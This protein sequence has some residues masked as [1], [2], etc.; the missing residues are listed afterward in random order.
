MEKVD[1]HSE[2]IKVCST[3]S[4]DVKNGGAAAEPAELQLQALVYSA[5]RD[6]AAFDAM[7]PKQLRPVLSALVN[8]RDSLLGVMNQ[9]R[10]KE[11]GNVHNYL[12]DLYDQTNARIDTLSHSLLAN[13]PQDEEER[14]E[15]LTTVVAFCGKLECPADE[16]AIDMP[17][18]FDELQRA[19][20]GESS[21][22][23]EMDKLVAD[24]REAIQN[25]QDPD[26]SDHHEWVDRVCDLEEAL[27]AVQ[28]STHSELQH[29]AT[30]LSEIVEGRGNNEG[31][32]G[33][34]G[35]ALLNSLLPPAAPTR[36]AANTPAKPERKV[37]RGLSDLEYAENRLL[38]CLDSVA[39]QQERGEDKDHN[40]EGYELL[41]KIQ[42]DVGE[43]IASK[44][45]A[46]TVAEA[47]RP[48]KSI[49]DVKDRVAI[50]L[51]ATRENLEEAALNDVFYGVRNSILTFAREGGSQ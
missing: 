3:A 47:M 26:R 46:R 19:W 35:L 44:Q 7:N 24:Y 37:L 28:C 40:A 41:F 36:A 32:L 48:C 20:A 22:I 25:S 4:A 31:D 43:V 23:A 17:E 9:P 14:R 15:W 8:V 16:L 42:C 45:E 29:K 33:H 6:K 13:R 1:T 2:T 34:F 10:V 21:A 11:G 27:F 5:S 51:A 18:L 30:I 50:L 12:D 38:N 39:V 49:A